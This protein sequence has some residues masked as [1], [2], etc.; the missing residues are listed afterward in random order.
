MNEKLEAACHAYYA[1]VPIISD[2]E[3]D[4]LEAS[5][6]GLVLAHPD[7]APLATVLTKVG[8]GAATDGKRVAHVR[9]MLSIENKYTMS[10]IV[11]FFN[12]MGTILNLEPKRDGVS[13]ELRYVDGRLSQA[14]TR[15]EGDAG[16]DMTM[17][18]LALRSIP[19]V[20]KNAPAGRLHVRGELVMSNTELARLN[21]LPNAKKQYV[22]T[23]NLVAG[24]MKLQDLGIVSVRDVIFIPWDVYNADDD[25]LMPD[26]NYIR[27][28]MLTAMGFPQY[29][30]FMAE[31]ATSVIKILEHLIALNAKSDIRADGVVAKVDS[32]KLRAKLGVERKFTNWMCCFKPQ[33]EAME[34]Y[35]R[36]VIWQ[37]GRTGVVSPVGICDPVNLAGATIT[38]V[39]LNNETWISDI[40]LRINSRIVI[41]RSGDVIPVVTRVFDESEDV[42]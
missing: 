12:K 18:V 26:S 32:H 35:L 20:L 30:G 13:C 37:V 1:G 27:M 34:T 17:Q 25:S 24:T 38:R 33:N 28:T 11:D 29:D 31:E 23:R 21:A 9:P 15:S 40:K 16:E 39:T 19:K 6:R 14:L 10:E 4:T 8:S 5:L 7:L 36:Q 22:S 41:C 42:E 3:Y 2:A